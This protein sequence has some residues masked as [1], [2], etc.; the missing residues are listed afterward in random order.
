ML[1]R[2][3]LLLAALTVTALPSLAQYSVSGTGAAI[4]LLPAGSTG[5]GTSVQTALPTA[6]TLSTLSVPVPATATNIKS[7]TITGIT[8]TWVG[9]LQVVLWDPTMTTGY[10]MLCRLGGVAPNGVGYS[11]DVLVGTYTFV[12]AGDPSITQ[13]WPVATAVNCNPGIYP[14]SYGI[15]TSG[16]AGVSNTDLASIPVVPGLWTLAIYDGAAGD[17]G[18]FTGWTLA[19]DTGPA[20]TIFCSGDGT[21]TACP[22]AN[23][24]L[25][26]N[27]CANSLNANGAH[28]DATGNAS[29]A[30]DTLLLTGNG[31]PDSSALYFQGTA[32]ANAGLGTVFGDGLRC[33]AGSVIRL[34]TKSNV[35]GTSQYPAAG[36][37][38]IGVKGLNAAGN[39]RQYQVWYRN[40]AAF[41]TAS[42]FNLSNGVEV[43][44]GT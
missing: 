31:M 41:C 8:H 26:G 7:V 24:G 28:I 32:R 42:T 15:W 10:N 22:C 36:D 1:K 25:A 44:W 43:T 33:A 30:T 9:D 19:G 38:S 40:A 2:S 27:G 17:T 34:G 39:V 20:S 21:G 14:Q 37:L 3:S 5:A 29:I 13:A 18:T 23:N 35:G 11:G 4:P 12:K 6:Y 16:S